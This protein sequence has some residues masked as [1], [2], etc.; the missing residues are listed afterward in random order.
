MFG[1]AADPSGPPITYGAPDLCKLELSVLSREVWGG[2][3]SADVT[4]PRPQDTVNPGVGQHRKAAA[5]KG[6]HQS[7]TV[8]GKST[9]AHFRY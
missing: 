6:P 7:V 5:G 3:G 1:R 4:Q 8:E 9:S 2:Q